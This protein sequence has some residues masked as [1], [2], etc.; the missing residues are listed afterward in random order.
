MPPAQL[1][2]QWDEQHLILFQI[3][4]VIQAAFQ[5]NEIQSR[6]PAEEH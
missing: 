2:A 3:D 1:M 6:Q 4:D 5:A